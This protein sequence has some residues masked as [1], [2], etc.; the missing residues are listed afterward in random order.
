MSL[1][2]RLLLRAKRSEPGRGGRP[3]SGPSA[4]P[5]SGSDCSA[6]TTQSLSGSHRPLALFFDGS[7]VLTRRGRESSSLVTCVSRGG[8]LRLPS[9]QRRSLLLLGS[10]SDTPP[11]SGSSGNI[12]LNESEP[13]SSRSAAL[14]R[15][16]TSMPRRAAAASGS[17]DSSSVAGD[18][19]VVVTLVEKMGARSVASSCCGSSAVRVVSAF[20]GSERRALA[21]FE[22]EGLKSLLVA[23]VLGSTGAIAAAI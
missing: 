12:L 14:D 20:F 13:G 23:S 9:S 7:S 6:A 15:S 16:P 4:T 8:W 21:S 2:A 17:N 10:G 1:A 19:T 18:T 5:R 22:S 11:Y 3:A